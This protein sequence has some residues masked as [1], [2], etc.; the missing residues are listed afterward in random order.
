V[1][2]AING[3]TARQQRQ[4]VKNKGTGRSQWRI[5]YLG[6]RTATVEDRPH[7]FL[8]EMDPGGRI[9]PHFHQVDQFQV[10]VAGSGSLGR[11]AVPLISLHYADHHTAYGPIEAGP[12]GLSLFTIR[13]KCDTGSIYVDKPGYKELLK[14]TKKRYVLKEN[15]GLSTEPVLQH[16]SVVV[17]EN[18]LEGVDVSDGLGAF[19]LRAGAGMKTAGPDPSNS[20]GHCYLVVNGSLQFDGAS[21]PVS[22]IIHA[23]SADAPLEIIA[24]PQGLE[25]IMF[26]FPRPET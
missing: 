7:V 24:G 5:D 14:P 13:A 1:I 19:I 25:M 22:S 12:F 6:T 15:I 10:F 3:E 8:V 21:Y 16:R 26:S 23:A 20:G 17:V 4:V 11:N 2:Q 18:L 9:R